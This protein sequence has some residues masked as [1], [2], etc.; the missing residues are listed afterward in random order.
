[1]RAALAVAVVVVAAGCGGG[2]SKVEAGKKTF[3]SEGCGS[4][5]TVAAAGTDGTLG[6]NLGEALA[7][8]AQ[9][10]GTPLDEFV[11]QSIL[12][13]NGYINPRYLAD[14]MPTNYGDLLSG[15]QIDGLVAFL[16]DVTS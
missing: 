8:D 6:P 16:V 4:C 7:P 3:V 11:R 9:A 14:T 10:A 12:N 13:P 5:H 2:G 15:D 1:M